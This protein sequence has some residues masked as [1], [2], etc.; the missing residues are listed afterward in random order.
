MST[1]AVTLIDES[2][3]KSR[4]WLD[5]LA[6]ELGRPGDEKYALRVLR[7]FFHTLRDRL[8]VPETAHLSAQ[9]P[10]FLRGIFYEGWRP[11]T[12]PERY[13]DLDTF[14]AKM[15]AAGQLA[16]ETESAY[17]VEASAR[18]LRRHVGARELAKIR[19]VL[20]HQLLPVLDGARLGGDDAQS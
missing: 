6:E 7:G 17:A 11:A 5:E 15:A 1:T 14:L 2:A 9:L 12:V 8:P 18:V 10:E 4:R 16:G 19:E 13:H 20:P 3:Q